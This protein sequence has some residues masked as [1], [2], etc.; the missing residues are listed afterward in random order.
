M[1]II[2]RIGRFNAQVTREFQGKT[3]KMA[4]MVNQEVVDRMGNLDVM[5][6][7]EDQAKMGKR[8]IKVYKDLLD[9]SG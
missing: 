6:R 5:E 1:C 2:L 4:K 3:V 7:M 8:G 9:L